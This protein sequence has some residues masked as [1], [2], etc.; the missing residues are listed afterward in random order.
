M[1]SDIFSNNL[2]RRNNDYCWS[3]LLHLSISRKLLNVCDKKRCPYIPVDLV[4]PNDTPQPEDTNIVH[5]G[6]IVFKGQTLYA[7]CQD[8]W[9]DVDAQVACKSMVNILR[10]NMLNSYKH[11]FT[12]TI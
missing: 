12:M 9:T 11:T 5:G 3:H 6:I 10:V 8:E 4:K 2:I 1:H 7:V